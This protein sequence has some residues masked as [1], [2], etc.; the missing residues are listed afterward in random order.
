MQRNIIEEIEVRNFGVIWE[1][2][3]NLFWLEI[4]VYVMED[5]DKG[6]KC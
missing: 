1:V 2:G 6:Y 3:N 5:L 4:R